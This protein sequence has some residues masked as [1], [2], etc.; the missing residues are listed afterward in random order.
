MI[1]GG[2]ESWGRETCSLE[3]VFIRFHVK[4]NKNLRLTIM[5]TSPSLFLVL[6]QRKE[7]KTLH[8]LT[9]YNNNKRAKAQLQPLFTF[10]TERHTHTHTKES[11]KLTTIAS[12]TLPVLGLY[13]LE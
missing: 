13:H 3:E 9:I 1:F 7:E 6:H 12:A 10:Y 2:I 5:A 4:Q 8:K 11:R